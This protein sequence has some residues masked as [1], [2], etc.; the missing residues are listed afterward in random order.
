VTK[1]AAKAGK[2]SDQGKPPLDSSAKFE[3]LLKNTSSQ[4]RYSLR[5]FITGSTARSTEAISTVRKLCE[6]Y[7]PGRYDLEVVDIYQQPG[8]A[9]DAQII[10]APTLIKDFPNPP[11]RLVGNLS[12]REKVIV[13]L[14]LRGDNVGEN[15][16][17]STV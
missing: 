16:T 2:T 1:K 15:V 11:K 13:G 14:N 3:K 10:A 8:Q 4:A 7:L 12:N 17:W 6:E 5:L 9:G